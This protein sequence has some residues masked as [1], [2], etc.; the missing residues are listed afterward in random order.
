[1]GAQRHITIGKDFG[2]TRMVIAFRKVNQLFM[3]EVCNVLGIST[4]VVERRNDAF[5]VL[6]VIKV[7]C[8]RDLAL[9]F[10]VDNTFEQD[11]FRCQLSFGLSCFNRTRVLGSQSPS[12]LSEILFLKQRVEGSIE[13]Y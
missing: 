12:L 5:L 6:Y 10:I 1:M 2:V 13:V 4:R 3:R 7:V 8:I 9:H 11:V